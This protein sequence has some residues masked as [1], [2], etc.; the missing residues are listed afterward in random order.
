M[1]QFANGSE[2]S[3]IAQHFA[4]ALE[5]EVH[6]ESSLR[7]A[8]ANGTFDI[9]FYLVGAPANNIRA[10]PTDDRFKV[11]YVLTRHD[12]KFISAD[13]MSCNGNGSG[14]ATSAVRRLVEACARMPN[15]SF[16]PNPLRG[17]ALFQS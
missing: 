7:F 4:V 1:I 14:C 9:E 17:S 6:D 15:V 16:M 12:G 10:Y 3:S 13:V 5:E 8:K 11:F 2:H